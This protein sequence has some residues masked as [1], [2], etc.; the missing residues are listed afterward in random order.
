MAG[1]LLADHEILSAIRAGSLRVSGVDPRK[2]DLS[3]SSCP[4]Q[5]SSLDLHI[6]DIFIPP[7]VRVD[8][9]KTDN[10]YPK[11]ET[12]YRLPPGHSV[13]VQTREE[14]ALN[15]TISAFGFP[16]ASLARSGLL[17]TNP[18]HVDPGYSGRLSFTLINMGRS[19][20]SLTLGA[21][22]VTLLVF[23]LEQAAQV[24]YNSRTKSTRASG[25]PLGGVLNDLSPDFANF[26]ERTQELAK[27]EVTRQ[28]LSL[29]LRKIYIPVII[30]LL[31]T[32]GAFFLGKST[33]VFSLAT[34]QHVAEQIEESSEPIS[35]RLTEAEAS[36]L[37]RLESLENSVTRLTASSD[38]LD[39]DERFDAI[40][41]AL[42][43][44]EGR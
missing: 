38:A 14:I 7:A 19:S 39:L 4:I 36:I 44:L 31:T 16:P 6:G 9:S 25:S 33:N 3:Q 17:M 20:C 23:Q 28:R 32:L 27:D 1:S 15:D 21:P 8:L 13:I 18:G 24:P 2:I 41:R 26:V 35:R 11:A 5:P 10:N 22:I 30:T 43:E 37:S 12:G 29:E 42:L 34:E 40:E